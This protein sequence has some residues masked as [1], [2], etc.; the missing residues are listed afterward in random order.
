MK[1]SDLSFRITFPVLAIAMLAIAFNGYLNYAKFEKH[2]AQVEMS[3]MKYSVDDVRGS[4][5]TGL[6]LGLP[7]R[8]IANA[9]E[10]ITF[11]ARKDPSILSIRV[12]DHEGKVV[13]RAGQ[14]EQFRHVPGNWRITVLDRRKSLERITP[15]SF[16]LISPLA[17]ITAD[18]SGALMVQY[19]RDVHDSTMREIFGALA[20]VNAVAILLTILAGAL[21]V[22]LLLGRALRRIRAV[23]EEIA[24][25]GI[26][27]CPLPADSPGADAAESIESSL[28][29]AQAAVREIRETGKNP[30]RRAS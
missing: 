8:A 13:F 2:L 16:L 14:E 7:V 25:A 3:R 19:S 5:E 20:P 18:F 24:A 29:A 21:G 9:Q 23:E 22:H 30:V 27:G 4:L 15:D 6:R 11:A 12:F 28:N 10:V 17:G 1:A 26:G